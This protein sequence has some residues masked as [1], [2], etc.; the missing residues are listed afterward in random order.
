MK[1]MSFKSWAALLLLV[2]VL[3]CSKPDS[4]ADRPESKMA[5][6]WISTKTATVMEFNSNKTGVV[7]LKTDAKLP[8]DIQFKWTMYPDNQF[9]VD[10]IV[11]GAANV[12]TGR[13]KLITD[14]TMVFEDDTFKKTQ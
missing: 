11:P 2:P 4:T 7:H 3:S 6:K 14:D 5:G 12:P 13:G 8:P 10:M 1:I 9:S